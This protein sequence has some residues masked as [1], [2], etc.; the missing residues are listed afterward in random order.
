M[1]PLDLPCHITISHKTIFECL[2]SVFIGSDLF[3]K[4]TKHYQH[5]PSHFHRDFLLYPVLFSVL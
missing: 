1:T 3:F 4:K 2:M 5:L